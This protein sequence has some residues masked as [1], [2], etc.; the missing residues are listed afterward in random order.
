M[1]T[2]ELLRPLPSSLR[3][4][5]HPHTDGDVVSVVIVDAATGDQF[6]VALDPATAHQL[7]ADLT[8][9]TTSDAIAA[10]ADR[11]RRLP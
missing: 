3:V 5:V 10:E 2:T 6:I 1:T 11:L 7:G 9:A 4:Q 8:E